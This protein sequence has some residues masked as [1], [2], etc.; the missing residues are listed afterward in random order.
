MSYSLA[1]RCIRYGAALAPMAGLTDRPL[2]RLADE[3]GAV[4][5]VSEMVSARALVMGDE[6][7]RGLCRPTGGSGLYGIQLFGGEPEVMKEA[8]RIVADEFRPDFIDLNLGC[9]A[10]KIAG[11]GSGSAL[12]RDPALCGRLVEAM[13]Q[14]GLPV[15]VK[16]RTG[17]DVRHLNAP[18]VVRACEAAGAVLAVV[19]GRSRDQQYTPP[20]HP[21]EIA[22]TVQAVSIPVLGNGDIL[23]AGDA[24][25]LEAETGCAGVVVG[26]GALGNP[27]LF[28]EIAAAEQGLALPAPP[29]LAERLAALKRQVAA[30]CEEKGEL[31]AM[32]QART[33]AGFYMKG[34]HGAAS[35]RAL[36]TGLTVYADLEALC[37]TAQELNPEA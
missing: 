24:L 32:R 1:G 19:H 36:T 21:E 37:R 20:I 22:R 25:R 12:L 34:L 5:T 16:L 8:A 28:G 14:S 10:P 13:A 17:Y 23:C 26:R 31:T 3:H 27:W 6:K 30:M 11:N 2:R 9:P 18:E 35:L 29:P 7:T 4:F 33:Q 15:T